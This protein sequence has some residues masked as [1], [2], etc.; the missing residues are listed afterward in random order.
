MASVRVTRAGKPMESVAGGGVGGFR[1]LTEAAKGRS[2]AGWDW[3][4]LWRKTW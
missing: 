4:G 2:E 1:E 3:E